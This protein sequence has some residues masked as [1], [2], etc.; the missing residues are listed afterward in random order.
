MQTVTVGPKYQVVIPKEVRE[1]LKGVKAGSKVSVSVQKGS[2]VMKPVK[3]DWIKKT[4]GSMKE[5]WKDI[6]PIAELNKMRDEWERK[7]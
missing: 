7:Y 4:Y 6:D 2:V 5:A 3:G 1:K